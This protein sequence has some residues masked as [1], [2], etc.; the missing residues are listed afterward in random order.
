MKKNKLFIN[1]VEYIYNHAPKKNTLLR[2]YTLCFR[3]VFCVSSS[4]SSLFKVCEL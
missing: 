2:P 3:H 4:S 1:D